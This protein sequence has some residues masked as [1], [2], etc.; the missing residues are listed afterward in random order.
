M[1][2]T[3]Q[4][5]FTINRQDLDFI[6]KQIKMAEGSNVIDPLTGQSM[7]SGAAL[8]NNIGGVGAQI[9]SVA[10]LPYGLRTVDGTWNHVMP[11][12]ERVGAADFVMPRLTPV[13]GVDGILGTADDLLR[14]A[15]VQPANF[16][17]PGP[18]GTVP[19]S[20]AQFLPG[21]IVFDSQPRV[22]S[23]LI[24]DQT[25]NNPAAVAAD[26]AFAGVF[27][28][29]VPIVNIPAPGVPAGT[30]LAIQNLSP[31]IGLSPPFN[32][33]MTFFGQFFDHGLDLIDKGGGT[34]F[35]PLLPDDPLFS[36][37]PGAPNFMAVTR[38][39]NQPGPDGILGTADDIHDQ[40]NTTTP[41]V[42]QNQ[43][44]TS[45]PS[46]QVFLREYARV[47]DG[48]DA[49]TA[50]DVVATGRLLTGAHGEGNW[51]EMKAQAASMLGIRIQDSDVGD[52]PLLATDRYGAFIRGAN[53]FVQVVTTTGLVE[54]DPT[55][56]G[57]AG[58]FLPANTIRTGHAFLNDIAHAAVPKFIGGV[59][60]PDANL[61]AGGSLDTPA[62]AGTYDNEL[63][64][65]HFA[66]GDGRG[67]ENIGL[68]TVHSVFHS[69]HNRLVEDYK[70]TMIRSGDLTALN[71]WLRVDLPVGT[72]LPTT[73]AAIDSLVLSLNASNAWDGERLFQAGRFVNEMEYQHLVF[74]EFARAVQPAVDPFVFSP[75]ANL[76]PAIVAEFANVVY[77]FGHSML[78]ENIA[79]MDNN[80]VSTD[81]GLIQ[82]FLNPL[83]FNDGPA[84]VSGAQQERD[85]IG[86]IVRGMSRQVGQEIDEF[87]VEA[88]RNNLV[89]LPL[90]LPTIN[91]I[92]ARDTGMPSFNEARAQFFAIGGEPALK[93]YVSWTD[94]ALH[95]KNPSSV[96]NFIAAY[97]LHPS[98]T[99][100]TTLEG[101]RSA[102]TALVMGVPFGTLG[103]PTHA[104]PGD[105]LD[106]LN[107][108]GATWS[109]ATTGLNKVD[110]WIGGLAEAK[111][112]FG[113]MLGATFNY[114]FESQMENLQNGDRFYYL[115]RTQG[116]NMLNQLEPNTFAALVMRN[117][118]LGNQDNPATPL[119]NE[120]ST[121]IPGLLF[122]TPNY[123]LEM[124]PARQMNDLPGVDGIFGPGLV[125][126]ANPLGLSDDVRSNADPVG[127]DP[128][129]NALLPLVTRVAPG[130]DG[131]GGVLKY[132]NGPDHLVLGGTAGNDTLGGGR[133]IDTLWGDAGNDIL[134][135]GDEADQV[136]G[137]D[138]DDIITDHGTPV[139]A[140]DF[141]R[142][143]DGDDVIDSGTG[144]DILFG[145]AGQD[146]IIVGPDFQEVFA[147]EGN[148]FVLGGQGPD[149]L[150]GNEGD[151]W[152]E[153]GEGHDGI[154]GE[155]SE[156]FF[157]S[158]I[159]GNDVLNG[160]GNDTDY[161]GESGDDIMVQGPG[162]QRN[163]GMLGFDWGINKG[164]PGDADSDLGVPFF[165]AQTVFTLRDRFDSV[166]G[167]SG[168]NGNDKLTGVS[169]PVGA[170][171]GAVGII[172][173]PA[174]D[175]KLLSQNVSLITGLAEL[176]GTTPAAVALLPKDTTV[177]D[178]SNGGDIIIGG[179]GSDTIFGK[180][181]NDII[182]GNAWLNVRIAFAKDATAIHGSIAGLPFATDAQGRFTVESMTELRPFMLSGRIDP[183]GLQIVREIIT[184]PVVAGEQD[185]ALYAG[186]GGVF[187][188]GA[189]VAS[190]T[191]GALP[192]STLIGPGFTLLRRGDGNV[193]VTDT[194]I[195]TVPTVGGIRV[196]DTLLA[197]EGVDTLR[198]IEIVRFT[199]DV[200]A[201]TDITIPAGIVIVNQPPVGVPTIN[202]TTPTQGQTLTA[203]TA[204][205]SDAN[206]PGGVIPAAAFSF[207]WQSS[208]DG[209]TFANVAGATAATFAVTAEALVNQQLRVVTSYTDAV[210]NAESVTSAATTVVGDLATGDFAPPAAPFTGTAGQDNATGLGGN[211]VMNGN[212]EN[213]ILTGAGGGDTLNGGA[214]N[215]VLNGNGGNDILNGGTGADTMTGGAGDDI[216][217]VDDALDVVVEPTGG[218][219]DEVQTTLNTYALNDA[220][221]AGIDDLRFTGVGNF[222]GTGNT[223]I[224]FMN[225]GAG[226][227]TLS[228]LGG[229]DQ[230]WG[231]G[232]V[233]TM[234]GGVG[235][236]IFQYLATTDTGVG[237]GLRD[238]ITD[239][240][241]G[242]D[243]IDVSVIDA[244]GAGGGNG[245]FGATP[246]ATFVNQANGA[247]HVITQG[248][249]TIVQFELGGD[250]D[251]I[252]DFEVQINGVV[253][254]QNADLIP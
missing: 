73:P 185:I 74:E 25:A 56:N 215:D 5:N 149:T 41:F 241:S 31:D 141:L 39:T 232:G 167:L 252:V 158:P 130:P 208:P 104:V 14:T 15:E 148:D 163:N 206:N 160:Q 40:R 96:I 140:A 30:S 101:K 100:E 52:C 10:I 43:T 244:N 6:L 33:W 133:G 3:P 61:T 55:A 209:V 180:A 254:F 23:N 213:D 250:G 221:G 154:S 129:L 69:E 218:G 134:D 80:L 60:A 186:A 53:G 120:G 145:G 137:G 109:A 251:A 63:L 35:V 184:A 189:G 227:D 183:G 50:L 67:N 131:N 234:T 147:G 62:P 117:S 79:R 87:V 97:G 142:G 187:L 70:Q 38:A 139:G 245:S 226:N 71:E 91:M 192:G 230:I 28:D 75:S 34:V 177:F 217:V 19:T 205:I 175:S 199:N 82:A 246:L 36:T 150:M 93:P 125:T 21:N 172:G 210:G 233:D 164:N 171:G 159:I 162:I 211:D 99:A 225:G 166:E 58:V 152:I 88:L 239:F 22:V 83:Q 66:T 119:V 198:G 81:V 65:R 118:N 32:G 190:T 51:G 44:Y 135:G 113:G 12:T 27:G 138:G 235:S 92:R 114:V 64:D 8:A 231:N 201:P 106:Y 86:N 195:A 249:N 169:F 42:D 144:N 20:Y 132:N 78:N 222:V 176:V 105:R 37:A 26:E 197:N 200:G 194:D 72:V 243:R 57:G 181:G 45:H 157:N 84:T 77:R 122:T 1:A 123:I 207:Q 242:Q 112:E 193:T 153:G 108:T 59:L 11:G 188:D 4:Y 178:P 128:V 24:S 110:L 127:S 143:N 76:N 224:N 29:R 212:A 214:G 155:N 248:G 124:D 237:A 121:H 13:A 156:L 173:A 49:G 126:L 253:A 2:T 165:A 223:L 228:A 90:D 179:A 220:G 17:G 47:A 136:F 204:G 116:T 46:H 247:W 174:T 54:G 202:D 48:P 240:V 115:S 146:F 102:A 9:A 236:D 219:I 18:A 238:I 95:L 89:G 16:F 182:D 196:A 216:Y 98:I 94:Y 151:D 85:S 68:T 229:N 191:L 168:W 170:V 107:S 203:S 7:I 161:D 103:N 111:L